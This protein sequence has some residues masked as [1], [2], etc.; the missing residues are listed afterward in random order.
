MK[1]LRFFLIGLLTLIFFGIIAVIVF[2]RF[3]S[4][5]ALPDYNENIQLSSLSAEVEVIRDEHAVP[6]IYAEN[7]SD[8]YRA[9]GY[10]MA[11]DRLWQM[12][13]LRRLT[14]GRLSEIF[15]KDL[16]EADMLFRSLHFSE[17]SHVVLDSLDTEI[18][19]SLQ[20]FAD[21][22]NEFID[23]NTKKLP[24]EF[25][26]LGYKPEKWEP[27]HSANLI[28]YMAWGLTKA[29]STEV[30]LFNI[31]Q[32][33]DEE[34]FSELIPDMNMH[35]VYIFPDAKEDQE[36]AFKSV[37]SRVGRKVSELGLQVFQAS[38]N[39]VVSP[40]KSAN[41]HA[42]LANDMHLDL[43]APGIWYQMHQVVPGELNVTGLV[44]PGQPFVI[45]GHNENVAWG[46]TN[47]MVDDLDFYRETLSET[48]SLKYRLNGEWKDIRVEEEIV[49]TKEG[50][51]LVLFNQFTHR[52]P[53]I[54]AIKGVKDKT[55]S[56]RWIGNEY[57]NEL[58]SVYL[59][60]RMKNWD[61]FKDAAKTF[62]SISQ[63]IAYADAEGNIGMY[64]AAGVPIREGD[65][66]FIV[67]GDTT[68]YDWKGLV[69]F[70]ELP[71]SYNPESGFIASAN[72]RTIGDNYPYYISRWYDLPNRYERIAEGLTSKEK[73]CMDDM[74][75]I[76]S[77][78]NSKWAE[79]LVPYFLSLINPK[80]VEGELEL[81]ALELIA[82]WDF[83]MP[84]E[85]IGSTIFEQFY[86]EFVSNV[87]SDELGEELYES[88]IK[89]DIL[90]TYFLDKIRLTNESVWFDD[91]LTED[92]IESSG[93]IALQ[94]LTDAVNALNTRLGSDI[95]KW[96]WGKV[97]TLSLMHPLGKVDMLNMVFKLN[98]GPF[99]VGGS[100]HTV[101]A[102]SYP[103]D[104]LYKANHGSSHRH[105]FVCGDW[106]KS[107]VI[108]PTGTSG[109]PASP[110]YCDQ[111]SKY[112]NYEYNT[113][114]FSNGSVEEG[115]V[116]EMRFL[117]E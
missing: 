105:L 45:C 22:V 66:I 85:S 108:I 5:K 59:Y 103:S 98:K 99:P 10:Q 25:T 19:V 43:N 110:Y 61:E 21:G 24:P 77:D 57:S 96:N 30:L 51:T 42:M 65:G 83:S 73:I 114:L 27:Y 34:Y 1:S 75:E 29:W 78:Q 17:K 38:N 53:I 90:A 33:I 93:D 116:Y 117:V 58:R 89:E 87:F 12:D 16:V 72:N 70:E 68:Q 113:E 92:K 79:K 46:M 23:N 7:E 91:I 84:K 100:Y 44:L 32:A 50:N 88:F 101:S 20:A 13:L 104:D 3:T 94:S 67:P 115:R 4:R 35:N 28:G 2:V 80:D 71:H 47:V 102:Y 39:W 76:Q 52:G 106:D 54:S 18:I 109:I 86:F 69:P 37:I 56:M 97:H 62:I 41:G 95:S 55:L 60:N 14:M 112:L 40:D 74:K 64:I 11:Q 63:N 31:S 9:V 15:G 107:Q 111:T 8:L 82:E 26:I 36:L 48:D 49:Y 6:H 81:A